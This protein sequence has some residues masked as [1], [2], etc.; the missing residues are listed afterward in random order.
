MLNIPR[1][2]GYWMLRYFSQFA[3]GAAFALV[4]ALC[5]CATLSTDQAQREQK[6]QAF[7]QDTHDPLEPM[8][9]AFLQGNLLFYQGI[10]RPLGGAYLKVVPGAVRDRISNGVSNLEEPRIFINDVLQGRGQAAETTLGRF[11]LNSTFGVAGMFDLA[12]GSG[13]PK[14]TGDFG[15]TLFVWGIEPGPYIVLPVMGPATFRDGIGRGV[16]PSMNPA[17]YAIYYWGGLWPSVGVG[18]FAA[19]S[20]AAGLDDVLAGSLDVYPRLRSLYLQKRASELAD[21]VGVTLTPQ[22]ELVEAPPAPAA[23]PKR[24]PAKTA[25][26]HAKQ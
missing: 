21:A 18:G 8:N 11:V 10:E 19:L 1:G 26:A 20:G 9:R 17:N 2:A 3:R 22:T 12:T 14:Q 16:D 23:K 4:A 24:H 5:G 7:A 13:M 6:L 15:Q 25:Q